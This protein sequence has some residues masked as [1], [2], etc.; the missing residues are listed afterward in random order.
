MERKLHCSVFLPPLKLVPNLLSS[1]TNRN[2]G[3]SSPQEVYINN[4]GTMKFCHHGGSL[5]LSCLMTWKSCDRLF[6]GLL[7]ILW[8]TEYFLNI[9]V[10]FPSHCTILYTLICIMGHKF[11]FDYTRGIFFHWKDEGW[12]KYGHLNPATHLLDL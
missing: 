12:H 11:F 1:L 7:K 10:S 4:S 6:H 9:L 5:Q 3:D 8:V 2:V